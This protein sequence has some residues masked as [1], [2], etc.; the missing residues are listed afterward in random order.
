MATKPT[1]KTTKTKTAR[2]KTVSEPRIIET[3]IP[4]SYAPITMW[5]YFG[6]EVL[7]KIP[8][9]GWIICICFA[10]MADNHNVRNFARA[11]FCLLIIYVAV[12]C[13][14]AATGMLGALFEATGQFFH[15]W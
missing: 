1:R 8:L 6:Y 11:Q 12:F 4:D 14:F 3:A 15:A 2:T 5:G 13:V 9:I 7:F 10:F